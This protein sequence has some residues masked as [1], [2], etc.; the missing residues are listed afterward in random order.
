MDNLIFRRQFIMS[1][2]KPEILSGRV[3]V[4]TARYRNLFIQAH[5]DLELCR[6]ENESYEL[7]M[8]GYALD[9]MNPGSVTWIFLKSYQPKGHLRT[10]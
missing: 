9:P 6:H 2:K 4:S 1:D 10:Y 3:S 5:P 8:L 7:I